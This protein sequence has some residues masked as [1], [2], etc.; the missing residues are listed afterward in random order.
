MNAIIRHKTSGE[1][2]LATL[3]DVGDAVG[4]SAALPF[5]DV[6]GR[7]ETDRDITAEQWEENFGCADVLPFDDD[8]IE[9]GSAAFW[10]ADKI[11]I[12]QTI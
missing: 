5:A 11:T 10:T 4:L 9:M 7:D 12:V 6:F 1:L 3:N 2:F 8:D